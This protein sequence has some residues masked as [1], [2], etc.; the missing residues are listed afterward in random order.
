MNGT[1]LTWTRIERP[2]AGFEAG[3]VVLLVDSSDGRKY[4]RWLGSGEPRFGAQVSLER[5][6]SGWAA[7]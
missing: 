4:A 3:R 6:G 5:E 7:R 2:P 1:I